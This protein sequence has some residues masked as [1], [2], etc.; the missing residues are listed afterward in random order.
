MLTDDLRERLDGSTLLVGPAR[1]VTPTAID[2][3]AVRR[4]MD[5]EHKLDLLYRDGEGATTRRV[6]WPF[7]LGYFDDVRIVVAWCETRQ[8]FRHFRADRILGITETLQRYPRRRQAL[9]K[10]WRLREGIEQD[11]T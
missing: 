3:T 10:D 1:T 11:R 2:L 6:V 9:L 5:A 4:A 8:A 7:A